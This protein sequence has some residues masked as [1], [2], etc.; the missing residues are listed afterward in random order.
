MTEADR[1]TLL[2]IAR[3]AIV[4]QVTGVSPHQPVAGGALARSAGVFVSLHQRGNLRGCIG[5]L[6]TDTPLRDAVAECARLA[7]SADPRFAAVDRSD[8]LALDIE[9]SILGALEPIAS[10]DEIEIGRHGLLIEHGRHRGLLLPQVATAWRWNQ[11]VF[12]EQA[13]HKAGLSHDAWQHGASLC[14]FEAEVFSERRRSM[15]RARI[16][17]QGAR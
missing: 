12:A 1:Q 8:L 13:C 11:R 6:E 3:A 2:R 14:R 17:S 5:H 4:A 9:I 7:C 15:E 10:P 16:R